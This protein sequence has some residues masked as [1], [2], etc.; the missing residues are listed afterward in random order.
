MAKAIE[1]LR[2]EH[3]N[4]LK[5][6]AVLDAEV[7]DFRETGALDYDLL[8]AAIDYIETFP[9]HVHHPKEERF[10]FSALERRNAD[11]KAL[12]DDLRDEHAREAGMIADLRAAVEAMSIEV[13]FDKEAFEKIVSDY[14]A[15]VHAHMR[16][17]ETEVFPLARDSL[18]PE[19]WIE[20]DRA[21]DENRDPLFDEQEA[22]R[23]RELLRRVIYLSQPTA[24]AERS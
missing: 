9:D 15:F 20:I 4:M 1:T 21:F 14:T 3:A 18:A 17:E 12:L 11:A 5:V 6:L 23:Y 2:R 19:D 8:F 22:D 16:K 13:P 10:L 7:Q 24:R